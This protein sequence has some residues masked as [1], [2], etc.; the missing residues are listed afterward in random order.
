MT[1][2]PW[3]RHHPCYA[4]GKWGFFQNDEG[5]DL[6]GYLAPVFEQHG[7]HAYISGHDH[8]LQHIRRNSVHYYVVGGGGAGPDD[9]PVQAAA[10]LDAK[11]ATLLHP[12]L[13]SPIWATHQ[14]GFGALSI[15]PGRLGAVKRF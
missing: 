1:D 3:A 6:A 8:M 15:G 9:E 10:V 13:A 4:T 2:S 5:T 7:V 12:A 14:Y 11:G